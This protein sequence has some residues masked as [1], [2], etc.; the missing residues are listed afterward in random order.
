MLR[1]LPLSVIVH[2]LA[3]GWLATWG[4]QVRQPPLEPT[5]ILRVQ[6]AQLPAVVPQVTQPV[7]QPEPVRAEPSPTPAPQPKPEPPPV[8]LPP[9]EVPKAQPRQEEPRQV[10][11]RVAPPPR[12]VEPE[13]APPTDAPDLGEVVAAGGP[14][15]AGTDVDFPFAWY[16][17]RVEGIIARQ[18]NPRQLGFREGSSRSCVVHF[19][20]DRSGQT[21]QVTLV[22]GSGVALFDREALRAVKSGRLPPLPPK[23]P[24]RALGVTFVFTLES[25]I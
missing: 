13:P 18:W 11:P 3:I 22:R 14:S 1:G 23:F 5:R 21:S 17:S 6:I 12:P 24:H 9:K 8:V 2:L 10:Q 16:L 4:G 7:S 15:V 25:G 20:I 19:V